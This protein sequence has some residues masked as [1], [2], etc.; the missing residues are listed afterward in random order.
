MHEQGV[1]HRDLKPEN[2]LLVNEGRIDNIKIIDFGTAHY[3]GNDKS[4]ENLPTKA[5]GTLKYM[6]PEVFKNWYVDKV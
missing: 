1:I 5:E 3:F 6:A 4:S 2:V